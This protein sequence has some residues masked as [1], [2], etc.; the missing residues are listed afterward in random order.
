MP[1]SNSDDPPQAAWSTL[2]F[3]HRRRGLIA[4]IVVAT[5]LVGSGVVFAGGVGFE[6][7]TFGVDSPAHEA[8]DRTADHFERDS[9]PVTQ[10]IVRSESTDMVSKPVLVE[11]LTLQ[12][13]IRDNPAINGTLADDQPTVGVANAVA[14]AS[15][16]RIAFDGNVRLETKRETLEGRTDEQIASSLGVALRSDDLSPPGQPSVASLLPREYTAGER[17]EAQLI[18]IVHDE[19]A[20]DAELLAA[21]EAVEST[22]ETELDNLE[23]VDSFVVGE[24]LSVERGSQATTDSFI[25]VGPLILLVV[26]GLLAV[27]YR[28]PVDVA[29]ACSGMGLVFVW[30]VGAMG[31]L[32]I[33]LNQLLIAVPCLLVGLSVDYYLHVAMRYREHQATNPAWPPA[34]AMAAG[35][36]GVLVAIGTT[37][38]TTATGF[39]AGLASPIGVLR[40]FSLVA[41]IGIGAAFVVFGLLVP[42]L[43][44]EVDQWLD[45]TDRSQPTPVTVGSLR[46]IK[47][48]LDWCANTA[49]RR[50]VAV[51]AVALLVAAGGAMGAPAVDTSTDR[52]QFLPEERA[53][54]MEPLPE[55]IR[56]SDYGLREQA[57][58]LQSTFVSPSDRTVE[59]LIEGD[60]TNDSVG[61]TLQDATTTAATQPTTTSN[62]QATAG[63]PAISGPLET[64]NRVAR[65][66]ETVANRLA[67]SD[68]TGDGVP[69]RNLTALFDAVVAADSTAANAT[70]YQGPDGEYDALRIEIAVNET[71]D[72]RAI[73]ADAEATAAVVDANPSLDATATGDPV[74]EA[75]QQ[76]AVLETVVVTFLLA[77]GVI[78]A[79]LCTVFRRR[80]GSWSIGLVAITPVVVAIAWL[81][82]TVWL[83]SLP[84]NAETALITAIAIGLGTDYTIHITERFAAERREVDR[85]TALRVAVGQTGG[86]VAA[87]AVTTIA[88]FGLLT[89]TLIPTL[90]RFGFVTALVVGYSFVASVLVLPALLVLWDRRQTRENKNRGD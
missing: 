55:A 78:A 80:H 38:L 74:V 28:D 62:T 73:R 43:R 26:V 50:P 3:D 24:A 13:A 54:W 23:S 8:G 37:T 18:V 9:Q 15:D 58:Y 70:I 64:V 21:Q 7:S 40:E 22:A 29:L 69:N 90:Q 75:V 39:L 59:I 47:R 11:T 31:W 82:G 53:G 46:S 10:L 86:A 77:L 66:N 35:L 67:D 14:I 65:E 76:Q 84:F 17:A 83:V 27:S 41:A 71:A 51:V 79:L 4:L 72:V 33:S 42:A 57:S 5:L 61:A 34:V 48:L 6:I 63:T 87:S 52:T 30:L 81:L 20:T 89:M 85:Q 49:S 25:L 16:P 2:F 68:T 56:P 60:V 12:Q 1:S 32:G 88:G 45:R 36:T 44:I 19:T